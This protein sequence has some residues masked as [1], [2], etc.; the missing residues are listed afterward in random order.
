MAGS[1]GA[2]GVTGVVGVVG[3]ALGR[4]DPQ[5]LFLDSAIR[6]WVLI[7]ITVVMVLVGVMRHH[8]LTLLNSP[9]KRGTLA[10]IREQRIMVRSQVLQAN[11]F[12]LPPS[13]F[14]ARRQALADALS[15]GSY[16]AANADEEKKRKAGEEEDDAPKNPLE[17]A[18]MDTML[19]QVKKQ[20]VM[21]VPQTVIMGWINFF[22]SGFVASGYSSSSARSHVLTPLFLLVGRSQAPVPV[23]AALQGHATSPD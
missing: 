11:Y 15:D 14:L 5:D 4:R 18:G 13:A 7:P 21:M 3:P 12:V 17:G 1:T 19:D 8:V 6:D 9:P 22:F 20:M 10:R 23:D 2:T 16:L